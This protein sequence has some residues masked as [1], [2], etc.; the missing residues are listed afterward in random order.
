MSKRSATFLLRLGSQ[1]AHVRHE[2]GLT[3]AGL[4][5]DVGIDARSI[6]RIEAGRTAPSLERLC[7]IAESLGVRPGS[8]L[9]AAV[10]ARRNPTALATSAR[11]ES[12]RAETSLQR[13]WERVPATRR[14]LALKM[15]RLLAQDEE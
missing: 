2:R 6:Q 10:G 12:S 9:D 14:A 1:I 13:A 4:A 11:D 15:L 3:Q 5:E 8:L 7:A